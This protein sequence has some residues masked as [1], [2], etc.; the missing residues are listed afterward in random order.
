MHEAEAQPG[1]TEKVDNHSCGT[2]YR[3]TNGKGNLAVVDTPLVVFIPHV[4]S[5]LGLLPFSEPSSHVL[6]L[7]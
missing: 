1:F 5:C 4:F 3:L 7:C 2:F 6:G